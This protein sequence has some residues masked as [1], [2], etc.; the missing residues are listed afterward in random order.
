MT[1]PL[2]LAFGQPVQPSTPPDRPNGCAGCTSLSKLYQSACTRERE[3]T[4]RAITAEARIVELT[5]VLHRDNPTGA[6][7]HELRTRLD[8]LAD[9]EASARENAIEN[10]AR[11]LGRAL[12]AERT[13]ENLRIRMRASGI[14]P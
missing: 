7:V 4:L 6:E 8:R 13:A 10:E 11:L 12:A 5:A 3:Q 2:R 14:T 1:S 9:Q